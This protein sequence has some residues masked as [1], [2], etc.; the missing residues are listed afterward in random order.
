M[1]FGLFYAVHILTIN[2]KVHKKKNVKIKFLKEKMSTLPVES[3][4]GNKE[5]YFHS[6]CEF[7]C[8]AN[9]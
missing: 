6:K 7:I 3:R 1:M 2:K 5:D 8:E 4:V 9:K